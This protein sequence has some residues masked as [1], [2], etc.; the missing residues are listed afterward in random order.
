MSVRPQGARPRRSLSWLGTA[1]IF[2][3][4]TLIWLYLDHPHLS[5][6]PG[7]VFPL[8]YLGT[9][10]VLIG[11]GVRSLAGEVLAMFSR[12]R[13]RAALQYHV[14][15]PREALIYGLILVVLCAG[16]LLGRSNML[17]LVFGLMAGPF[18][19][20][21]QVTLGILKRLSVVRKLPA[22]ATVGESFGVKLA[23]SNRK[24]LLSSWMV[25][26]EDLAANAREQLAPVV[27]FACVP[28]HSTRE[29]HYEIRPVCRGLHE[30]GPV[31]VISRFPLG[32]MERSIE[33]G[34]IERLIVYPRIGKLTSRWR[35]AP[36]RGGLTAE[37]ARA[38]LGANQE[39]F[40]RL[41]EY[42]GGD[43]PRAIHWR[44]TARRNQLMV[45]EYEH[46]RRQDVLLA[47]ELWLPPQPRPADHE[48]VELAV[49]LAASICVDHSQTAGE[50]TIEVV[51][52]GDGTARGTG[53]AGAA[54]IEGLLEMLALAEGGPAAGLGDALAAAT[55]PASAR[56][57]LITT[58]A[59]VFGAGGDGS[60]AVAGYEVLAA[61]P[62]TICDYLEFDDPDP[63]HQA[64]R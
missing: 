13:R 5:K 27:L 37:G 19:L 41:R 4:L 22:H 46:S 26:V 2:G 8:L 3:G 50:S 25:S 30:F 15:M 56:R 14:R 58:R 45:R 16:A 61:D 21:G 60:H 33:L 9:G 48:R 35:P 28:P 39:E 1:A 36:D 17:M 11:W 32:L 52:C 29:A 54:A 63:E 6:N 53:G 10:C 62:R 34:A 57:V 59:G 47:V 64:W 43:N 49:S 7:V 20:N 51:L 24:K 55:A 23:L 12:L 18:I 44:T 42:R 38:D 31:R 40:H